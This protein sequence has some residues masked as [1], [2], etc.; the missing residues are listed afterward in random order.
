MMALELLDTKW[1]GVIQ[2]DPGSA[3]AG[4]VETE[5]ILAP[6]DGAAPSFRRRV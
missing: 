1:A 5:H 2:P 3:Q 6:A 4:E